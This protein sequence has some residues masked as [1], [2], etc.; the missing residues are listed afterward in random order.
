ME[1]S[2][3]NKKA[4]ASWY[5]ID[6]NRL[7]IQNPNEFNNFDGTMTNVNINIGAGFSFTMKIFILD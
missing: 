2:F 5:S 1:S 3:R 4:G 6:Y 7:R